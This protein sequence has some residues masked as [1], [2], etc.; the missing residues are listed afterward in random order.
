MVPALQPGL[1]PRAG[2][3]PNPDGLKIEYLWR[4]VLARGSLADIIEN[5]AQLLAQKDTKTG[6]RK[7]K[8]IWPRYQQLDI[9]RRLLDDA[10]RH[11]A[12]KRY[13]IQHS[14]GSGKSYSIAWLAHQMIPLKK[15][16]KSVFDSI[17][18]VTY[19]KILDGQIHDTIRQY[20]QVGSTVGHAD[21]AAD[22]KTL[23]EQGKKVIISTIQKFPFIL[24]EIGS[25]HRHRS[26]TII[27]DEA[28]SSQGGKA[29]G[30][31]AAALGEAG[32]EDGYETYEDRVNREIESRRILDN[33]SYF[34]FTATPKNKT[35]ELFGEPDPQGDGTVRRLPFHTYSMKQAIQEGFIL[36]VLEHYTPVESYRLAKTVEEDPEYDVRKAGKKLRRYVEGHDH[37]IRLKAEIMVDHFHE[38]VLAQHRVGGK[39]RAN[40]GHEWDRARDPVLP[41]HP[42]LPEGAKESPRDSR[43]VL[44]RARLRGRQGERG[45]PE[46]PSLVEDRQDVPAGPAQVPRLRG[47]VPDRL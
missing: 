25:G 29:A 3:P 1:E 40:G 35:I 8:Q 39:A 45:Q 15:D 5:Y 23:I 20:A 44:G 31:M 7:R 11:G 27:I 2:N 36:D 21:R 47:Q 6:R 28:H 18:V 16:G 41:R 12:G 19:R 42:R 38:Q 46:R 24:D 30:A 17:I 33:A 14:A 13:L 32:G 26:F 43:R 22:L 9:V 10:G 4:E 37:A 34:A